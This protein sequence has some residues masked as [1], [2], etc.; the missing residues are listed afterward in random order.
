MDRPGII[1]KYHVLFDHSWVKYRGLPWTSVD[2]KSAVKCQ[3][4]VNGQ[5]AK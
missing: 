4:A 1:A 2:C 3:S 5:L